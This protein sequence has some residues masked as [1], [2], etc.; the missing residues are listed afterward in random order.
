MKCDDLMMRAVRHQIWRVDQTLKRYLASVE[1]L[2]HCWQSS[3]WL[4][5]LISSVA[6][7]IDADAGLGDDNDELCNAL[8]VRALDVVV[9][10]AF[11]NGTWG[12]TLRAGRGR[13]CTT[14]LP[15]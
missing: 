7:L 3:T 8:E 13:L 6:L 11:P 5:Q 12:L 1:D 15:K 9:G 10:L 14:T 2:T 4:S